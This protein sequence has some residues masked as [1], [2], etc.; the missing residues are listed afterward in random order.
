MRLSRLLCEK[1]T[2]GDTPNARSVEM[3]AAEGYATA[4]T[5]LRQS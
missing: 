5:V 4:A 3:D 2:P 1:E